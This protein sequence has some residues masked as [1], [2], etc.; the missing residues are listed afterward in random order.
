MADEIKWSNPVKCAALA[1]SAPKEPGLFQIC[2]KT[3]KIVLAVGAAGNDQ[4]DGL[5]GAVGVVCDSKDDE[6]LVAAHL[7]KDN[8]VGAVFGFDIHSSEERKAF[9]MRECFFLFAPMP[10]QDQ[11]AIDNAKSAAAESL[12]ARYAGAVGNYKTIEW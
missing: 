12:K 4:T 7:D 10:G 2:S 8:E 5:L 9:I 11:A 6:P 3:P 1:D